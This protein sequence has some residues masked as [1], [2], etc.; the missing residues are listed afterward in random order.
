MGNSLNLILRNETEHDIP[1][2][3]VLYRSLRWDEFAAL[4]DW[5]D[6]QKAAFLDSQFDAQRKHYLNAYRDAQFL[7]IESNGQPIGRL[8]V[9]RGLKDIRVVDIGLLPNYR[10][11]GYGS[12]LLTSIF[13]EGD[14]SDRIVSVH[15]E[16][17]NPARRLYHR[18]GFKEISQEGPYI[19]MERTPKNP[20][21]SIL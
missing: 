12:A 19:L 8:Y 10:N 13:A 16:I 11:C 2:L 6:E 5:S 7:V 4:A 17:F 3:R 15:V 20:E 1:F 9:Y 21:Q 14:T 18:L